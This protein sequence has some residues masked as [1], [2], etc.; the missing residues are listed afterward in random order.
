MKRK[1]KQNNS[2]ETTQIALNAYDVISAGID[3]VEKI[4]IGD[5]F[6]AALQELKQSINLIHT[7]L[8]YLTDLV[9]RL[10]Q[11]V[12]ELPYTLRIAQHVEKI[13]SCTNDLNNFLAKPTNVAAVNN[14]KQCL[15]IMENV[16]AIGNYL[17]GGVIAG[18]PPSLIYIDKKQG[19]YNGET[20]HNMFTYLYTHFI[21]GCTIAVTAEGLT[22]LGSATLFR[23]ECKTKIGAIQTYMK[24]FFSK[25]IREMCPH[26]ISTAKIKLSKV[27]DSTSA[28]IA[29]SD[30]FPWFQFLAL[31]TRTTDPNITDDGT[32]KMK[33]N[34][35]AGTQTYRLFWTDSFVRFQRDGTGAT[36]DITVDTNHLVNAFYGNLNLTTN[37]QGSIMHFKA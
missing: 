31:K 1:Q 5:P 10:L 8:D 7:K 28:H 11:L 27:S 4:V 13:N 21:N 18:S 19:T 33:S 25:C 37:Q 26:F 30:A 16:R 17:S 15:N 20:I 36:L 24:N 12:K 34:N 32:F 14:L 2:S 6:T 9:E 35:F 22:Y 23:N 3:F 29:M